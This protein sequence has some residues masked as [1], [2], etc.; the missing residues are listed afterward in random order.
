MA[1]CP[2][3]L[4]IPLQELCSYLRMPRPLLAEIQ[5]HLQFGF[6]IFFLGHSPYE[7]CSSSDDIPI[8][9]NSTRPGQTILFQNAE[10]FPLADSR[11]GLGNVQAIRDS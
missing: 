9:D 3:G 4:Q 10:G 7:S 2:P 8:S 5:S 11:R 1:L 6:F